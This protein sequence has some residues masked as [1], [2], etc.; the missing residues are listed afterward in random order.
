[1]MKEGILMK[2]SK[3]SDTQI[4]TILKQAESG[5]PV[6]DLNRPLFARG[7]NS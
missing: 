4:M 3:Y 1:M 2:K 6:A 5:V 7:S